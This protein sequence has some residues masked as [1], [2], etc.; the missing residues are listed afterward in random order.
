MTRCVTE[1]E[2]YRHVVCCLTP[3]GW[4]QSEARC[5]ESGLLGK[6]NPWGSHHFEVCKAGQLQGVRYCPRDDRLKGTGNLCL[7]LSFLTLVPGAG[8]YSYSL[9]SGLHVSVRKAGSE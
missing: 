2:C 5:V 3:H 1:C 7:S 8:Q 4:A 6:D 9:V